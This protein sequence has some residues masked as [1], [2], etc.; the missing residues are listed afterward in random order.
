M[1]DYEFKNTYIKEINIKM[2]KGFSV[3][4]P[5]MLISMD[6]R[7]LLLLLKTQNT[8]LEY[9]SI[10]ICN[11]E[12]SQNL[13]M[14]TIS[15]KYITKLSISQTLTFLH[16]SNSPYKSISLIIFS[17]VTHNIYKDIF[18]SFPYF[19]NKHYITIIYL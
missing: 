12:K 2:H 18:K 14:S 3:V 19:I 5:I 6:E 8:R 10:V 7:I 9:Q 17:L 11:Y 16:T 15:R 13:E 1:D 4:Q